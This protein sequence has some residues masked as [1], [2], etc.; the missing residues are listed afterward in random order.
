MTGF[1]LDF[2]YIDQMRTD[3]FAADARISLNLSYVSIGHPPNEH[4]TLV[5]MRA[6]V[7]LDYTEGTCAARYSSNFERWTCDSDTSCSVSAAPTDDDD[8][9]ADARDCFAGGTSSSSEILIAI[10]HHGRC[11]QIFSV[12]DTSDISSSS[13]IIF[14]W[15]KLSM[16]H[17]R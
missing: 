15:T 6:F 3:G 14:H 7:R 4:T 8:D 11:P 9:A 10:A 1:C 17:A 5:A 13:E 12:S 16:K 2:N